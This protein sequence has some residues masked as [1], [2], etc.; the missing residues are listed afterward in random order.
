MQRV[1]KKKKPSVIKFSCFAAGGVV[2]ALLREARNLCFHVKF[3]I[4]N[5]S[6]KQTFLKHVS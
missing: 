3:P 4:K 1:K 2:V 6:I 5:F